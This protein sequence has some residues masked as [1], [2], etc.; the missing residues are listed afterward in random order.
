[1]HLGDHQIRYLLTDEKHRVTFMTMDYCVSIL[2]VHHSFV[3]ASRSFLWQTK[4]I[5]KE[6]ILGHIRRIVTSKKGMRVN[7][8]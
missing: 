4:L 2:I 6:I 7:Y 8:F 5:E 3:R 1:M